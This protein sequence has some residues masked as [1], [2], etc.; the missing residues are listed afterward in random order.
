[1]GELRQSMLLLDTFWQ[2]ESELAIVEL[3]DLWPSALVC[4]HSFNSNYLQGQTNE[5]PYFG[6]LFVSK[7]FS[8]VSNLN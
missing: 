7:G 4:F 5:F 3:F 8:V 6:G 1:M 2:R